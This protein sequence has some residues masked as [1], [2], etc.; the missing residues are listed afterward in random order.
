MHT[1]LTVALIAGSVFLTG[2]YAVSAG[3]ALAQSL[4]S[5]TALLAGVQEALFSAVGIQKSCQL[6]GVTLASGESRSFYIVP[7][8]GS[9]DTCATVAQ[10]RTCTDGTLSGSNNYTYANCATDPNLSNVRANLKKFLPYV[11]ST[12]WYPWFNDAIRTDPGGRGVDLLKKQIATIKAQ[13][14]N[15]VWLGG[16][17][18]AYLQPV[19]GTWNPSAI[20]ALKA[21]LD[22]LKENNMR[23][24]IQVNYVGPG[25]APQGISGCTWMNDPAQVQKFDDYVTGLGGQLA[26]YNYMIFYSVFTEQTTGCLAQRGQFNLYKNLKLGPDG[27]T[28]TWVDAT[29]PA[30]K[31]AHDADV[32]AVNQMLKGSIGRVTKYLAPAVRKQMFIG[33]HDALVSD[34]QI[35]DDWPVENPIDFD[36]FSFVYYPSYATLAAFPSDAEIASSTTAYGKVFDALEASKARIRRFDKNIPLLLGEFGWTA[37][38]PVA[39]APVFKKDSPARDVAFTALVDWSVLRKIG[40]N[41]WSWVPPYLDN[42]ARNDAYGHGLSLV[43]LDGNILTSAPTL[44]S[45]VKTIREKLTGTSFGNPCTWGGASIKNGSSV[46]AYRSASVASGQTCVSEQRVCTN[47]TLSGTYANASCSV[48]TAPAATTTPA[49]QTPLTT[50]SAV[51]ASNGT[52][53]TFSWPAAPGATAYY[54]NVNDATIGQYVKGPNAAAASPVTVA[55]TPG[56]T[57]T[58]WVYVVTPSGWSSAIGATP[59]VC[60]SP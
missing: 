46:T 37:W 23:A 6:G 13:G 41:A 31:A 28:S 30:N 3:P 34:E 18:W 16:F 24:I 32:H 53:A 8:V 10:A 47:G 57:Y 27:T 36:F 12:T 2:A 55:T 5:G 19:P 7:S 33:I 45:A 4:G 51:C 43:A 1:R 20:A 21:N 25:Y 44:S 50:L 49:T 54:V 59:I 52:Q 14:F 40:F 29:L 9:D 15:T 39:K 58:S 38:D 48:S 11:W 22:V 35:T 42:L 17:S 56:H 26:R 60:K